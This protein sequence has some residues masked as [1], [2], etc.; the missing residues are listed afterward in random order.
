LVYHQD[1]DQG[2]PVVTTGDWATAA[3]KWA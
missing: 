2:L 1:G 3:R